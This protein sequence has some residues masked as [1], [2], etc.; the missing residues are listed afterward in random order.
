MLFVK[1]HHLLIPVGNDPVNFAQRVLL[2]LGCAFGVY[3]FDH[4]FQLHS[5]YLSALTVA[6]GRGFSL[7]GGQAL[8]VSIY[9]HHTFHVGTRAPRVV[10]LSILSIL[11]ALFVE[12]VYTLFNLVDLVN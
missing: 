6:R 2:H 10:V 1:M 11:G 5:R 7:V 4:I 8:S 9:Q 12:V 3:V